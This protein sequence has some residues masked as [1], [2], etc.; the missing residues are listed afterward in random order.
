MIAGWP[1][2]CLAKHG[3]SQSSANHYQATGP[4]FD[5]GRLHMQMCE[6]DG[7]IISLDSDIPQKLIQTK[8]TPP[9]HAQVQRDTRTDHLNLCC[10]VTWRRT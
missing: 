4:S 7:V 1:A 5:G 8:T 6:A 10:T 9:E 2:V 3:G